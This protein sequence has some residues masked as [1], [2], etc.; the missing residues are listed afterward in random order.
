MPTWPLVRIG[1][2]AM[3]HAFG[4]VGPPSPTPPP[5]PVRGIAG[6]QFSLRRSRGRHN[7]PGVAPT[8]AVQHR[9]GVAVLFALGGGINGVVS[10]S[11]FGRRDD[12]R[13][14]A[15]WG[16]MR[17]HGGLILLSAFRGEDDVLG[18]MAA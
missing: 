8:V 9:E 18:G 3:P 2:V 12:H 7:G 15:L 16:A 6:A 14:G 5:M 11:S 10:L 4:N 17:H 1:G 13:I